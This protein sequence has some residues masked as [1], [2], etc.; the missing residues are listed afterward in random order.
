MRFQ[1]FAQERVFDRI[2][3]AFD[4]AVDDTVDEAQLLASRYSRTGKRERSITRTPPVEVGSGRIEARI[5]SPLVSAKA[6][7]KGAYVQAKRGKYLVF[8][9]PGGVVKVEAVRLAPQPAVAP[10]AARFPQFMAQR[11]AE[12]LR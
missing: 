8:R 1:S 10:A 3:G 5:G 12:A 6:K 11:L 4:A 7:E 9:V 2:E